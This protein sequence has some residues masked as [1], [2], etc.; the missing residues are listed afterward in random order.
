[1]QRL[2]LL[3]FLSAGV[4]LP[5]LSQEAWDV[6]ETKWTGDATAVLAPGAEQMALYRLGLGFD[7]NRVLDNGLE[8]G[9]VVKLDAELDN[10]ARSGFSGIV[11]DPASG[12]PGLS[13]AFSGLA[14]AD[15]LE[16]DG[17]RGVLQTAYVYAEGGYGEVRIGRDE[18]VAKRFSEG[19]PSLFSTL[20]LHAPKLDPDGGAIVRTDHDLTGPATKVSFTT[21]RIIGLKGG[22]SFT[23]EAD[24]RGLDRD[25]VRILPGTPAFSL[26]NAAE[27]SVSF[28]HRFRESGVRVRAATA[29]SRADV[30]AAPTSPVAYGT[31]QTWSAG[32]NAEWKDTVFG[33][34]WLSS[35]NGLDGRPGD[36]SA[37][38]AGVTHTAFGLDWGAE[39]GEATDDSAGV[40]GESWRAGVARKVNENARLTLGY[41]YDS[42]NSGSIATPRMLGGRGIVLE[43]TLSR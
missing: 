33:A 26:S 25:P 8:L 32:A 40:K 10:G 11:A 12:S 16:D 34:S 41:R 15:G 14:Q 6:W 17:A 31:V 3:A 5:A 35:D 1:M 38:T 23:P 22:I 42:L 18:G 7:T 43:I 30:D 37:W 13:G 28:N 39:Y 24:V 29:F 2:T 4:C 21:P 36:Y 19:A 20:S 27:A 9:L